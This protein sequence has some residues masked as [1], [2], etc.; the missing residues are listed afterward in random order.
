MVHDI[1][2]YSPA[3]HAG[4]KKGDELKSINRMP[5]SFYSLQDINKIFSKKE[6]KKIRLVIKRN[7]KRMVINF[8][9]QKLI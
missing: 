6:G 3:F 7:G 1:L 5:I 8:K 2:N 9:L 4:L